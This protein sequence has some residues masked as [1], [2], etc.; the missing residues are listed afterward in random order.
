MPKTTPYGSWRSPITA[1]LICTQGNRLA[2]PR[3]ADG[4][5]YWIEGRPAE[6]GRSVLVRRDAGGATQDLTPPP[7]S[8]RSRVHE[9]GGG[10]AT[11]A[12]GM[13]YFVNAAD[14]RIYSHAIG[15][16]PAP[17]TAESACLHA[18]LEYDRARHRLLVV[19]EDHA[20]AGG[21]PVNRL[22]A[23]DC[24]SGDVRTLVAGADFYSTPRLSPDGSQLAWLAWDH[25]NMPWDGVELWLADLDD[26]GKPV[27]PRIVA[28][29]DGESIFQ[30]AFSPAGVLHF[31]S[32][33]TGWWNL[34]RL[35]GE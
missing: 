2:E 12:D 35:D 31:V 11:I 14:Q 16:E 19:V 27:W 13:V 24:A 29:G 32:D 30:P 6:V 25:P 17:L 21:E 4:A 8:V 5:L 18:D 10:A 28:G 34:Y 22:A 20:D 26:D 9:Y 1:E 33:R 23:V 3:F 7:F 15:D